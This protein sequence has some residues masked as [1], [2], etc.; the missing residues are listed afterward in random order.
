MKNF[1]TILIINLFIINA[2]AYADKEA[3]S[4]EKLKNVSGIILGYGSTTLDKKDGIPKKIWNEYHIKP[5]FK[6]DHTL[7]GLDLV[8]HFDENTN[9]DHD[10]WNDLGDIIDKIDYL[11][12]NT[13]K[14]PF[15]LR[16]G[17]LSNVTFGS[18]FVVNHYSNMITY[19]LK[20]KNV[21][22]DMGINLPW[23]DKLE[24]FTN[25]LDAARIFGFRAC[26]IPLD[27]V[28]VGLNYVL[29]KDPLRN[30][31]S[32]ESLHFFSLDVSSPIVKRKRSAFYIYENLAKILDHG[33]GFSSGIRWELPFGKFNGEY[34]FY[35]SNFTPSYFN[36][37][38]DLDSSMKYQD[39]R[40]LDN[41]EKFGGFLF[42]GKIHTMENHLKLESSIEKFMNSGRSIH[43][44]A[45]AGLSQLPF[46][47]LEFNLSYDDK[48]AHLADFGFDKK[49]V[50]IISDTKYNI[51]KNACLK[52][53]FKRIYN[54][55]GIARK[56]SSFSTEIKF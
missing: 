27:Y 23:D 48:D 41:G 30:N 24:F 40:A 7:L 1:L 29:D 36:E 42:S 47:N 19:P 34:R 52:I 11:Y 4:P 15:Y 55:I 16:I 17:Q 10:D 45:K 20:E 22:L 18:G 46:D 12:Y 6:T 32:D 31:N 44:Y 26:F 33:L 2:Y 13:E 9:M 3:I 21:G 35:D 37:Y 28:E 5:H 8:F 43:F 50:T 25:D 54:E 49:N 51:S 14:D 39:L 53:D 56:L 38:Y